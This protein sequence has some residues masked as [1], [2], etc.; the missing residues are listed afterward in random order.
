MRIKRVLL[1][2]ISRHFGWWL[3]QRRGSL[4]VQIYKPGQPMRSTTE[5]LLGPQCSGSAPI[6]LPASSSSFFLWAVPLVLCKQANHTCTPETLLSCAPYLGH[7]HWCLH[8]SSRSWF[9]SSTWSTLGGCSHQARP[10]LPL[11]P[12]ACFHSRHSIYTY[13]IL[14]S[15]ANTCCRRNS[16]ETLLVI[17]YCSPGGLRLDF[18]VLPSAEL[19]RAT[20]RPLHAVMD[21]D[22]GVYFSCTML[23][24]L[25]T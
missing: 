20:T 14:Y 5:R 2:T 12:L 22:S 4:H 19:A 7:L 21:G 18:V 1:T 6:S 16:L 10:Q 8:V 15:E 25:P 11:Y 13:L 17:V 9:L 24:D 23:W 3:G